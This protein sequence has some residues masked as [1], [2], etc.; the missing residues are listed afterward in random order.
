MVSLLTSFSVKKT[1]SISKSEVIGVITYVRAAYRVLANSFHV[2][3]F[4]SFNSD[5]GFNEEI[6]SKRIV[7]NELVV[8]LL[9]MKDHKRPDGRH[10]RWQGHGYFLCVHAITL[11]LENV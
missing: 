4:Q 10:T 11:R 5:S 3:T 2:K 9:L 8:S 1:A 6:P 7:P